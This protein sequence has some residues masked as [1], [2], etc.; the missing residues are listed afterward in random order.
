MP[1]LI[2]YSCG[3][4]TW[5]LACSSVFWVHGLPVSVG[6]S[7]YE[8]CRIKYKNYSLGLDQCQSVPTFTKK[9]ICQIRTKNILFVLREQ[10]NFTI[11]L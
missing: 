8:K 5:Q 7:T 11:F 6:L 4:G 2:L 1:P 9:K 3:P 10:I